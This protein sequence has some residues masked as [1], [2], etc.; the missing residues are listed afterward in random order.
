M[1][2]VKGLLEQAKSYGL[3]GYSTLRKPG[4]IRLIAEARA[5]VFR[6]RIARSLQTGCYP[7][8]RGDDIDNPHKKSQRILEL[9][10]LQDEVTAALMAQK[11]E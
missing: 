1:P 2:T 5:P 8:L 11:Y 7:V 6:E 4:L 10:Q 3:R 9:R